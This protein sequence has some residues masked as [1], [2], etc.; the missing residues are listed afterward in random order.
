MNALNSH[1]AFIRELL[2]DAYVDQPASDRYDLHGWDDGYEITDRGEVICVFR[3]PQWELA[4][5]VLRLLKADVERMEARHD[6]R[7]SRCLAVGDVEGLIGLVGAS[8]S[9]PLGRGCACNSTLNA[10]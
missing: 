1:S 4:G 2:G 10:I 7:A 8:Q 3:G 6:R 9:Q 5:K